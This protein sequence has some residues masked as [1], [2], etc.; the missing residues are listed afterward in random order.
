MDGLAG[1]GGRRRKRKKRGRMRVRVVLMMMMVRSR[2][3]ERLICNDVGVLADDDGE[4]Q[5]G[6]MS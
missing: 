4:G 3:W 6:V 2:W 5:L 1:D